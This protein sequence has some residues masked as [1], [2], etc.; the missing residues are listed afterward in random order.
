M[1][2]FE[3]GLDPKQAMNIGIFS[4][5]TFPTDE[6]GA[7]FVVHHLPTILKKKK[8]PGDILWKPHGAH[9]INKKYAKD[10]EDYTTK[11][12]RSDIASLLPEGVPDASL[13]WFRMQVFFGV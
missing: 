7:I 4:K 11:Y 12:M 10:I 13:F 6:A 3:R 1:A 8:I 5:R 2:N 9:Y